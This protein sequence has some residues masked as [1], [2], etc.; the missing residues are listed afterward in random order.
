MGATVILSIKV[1]PDSPQAPLHDIK[2]HIR[3]FMEK[4]GAKSLSIDE[5]DVAFGLKALMVK[6]A[7]PEE[8]GTDL[9]ESGLAGIQNVSSVTIEDYRRAFG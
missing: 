4:H 2:N 7:L 3:H 6:C 8:K 5:Q 9:I 1:M